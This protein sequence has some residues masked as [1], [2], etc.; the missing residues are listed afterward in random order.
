MNVDK[1]GNTSAAS[2]ILAIDE[3]SRGGRAQGGRPAPDGGLRR[4]IHLGGNRAGMEAVLFCRHGFPA[5]GPDVGMG[6]TLPRLS[7]RRDG[8]C[9]KKP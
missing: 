3:A 8:S 6:R 5:G 2:V 9:G 1:Y 4:R 7:L